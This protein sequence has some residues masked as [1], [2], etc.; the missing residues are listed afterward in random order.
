MPGCLHHEREYNQ[1]CEWLCSLAPMDSTRDYFSASATRVLDAAKLLSS[2][3]SQ[4]MAGSESRCRCHCT[5]SR[6]PL[7]A[8]RDPNDT[9]TILHGGP[10]AERFGILHH[11]IQYLPGDLGS[12]LLGYTD[13]RA[14]TGCLSEAHRVE[15]DFSQAAVLEM[16]VGEDGFQGWLQ[17]AE[18]L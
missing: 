17:L 4:R 6:I 14:H 2:A 8:L 10:R 3:S 11:L 5:I 13:L 15:S 1:F 7:L 9:D 18:P 16:A 12:R